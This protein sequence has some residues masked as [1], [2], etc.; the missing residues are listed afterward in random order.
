MTKS[1]KIT[2]LISIAA[3]L[4]FIM[5]SPWTRESVPFWTVMTVSGV[6]LTS[7]TL[8]SGMVKP[9]RPDC[10]FSGAV[11]GVISAIVLWGIFWIG[12]YLSVRW[13]DFAAGQI[14]SI[15]MIRE[16]MNKTVVSLLLLLIIGPA[17]E[18]FWR[19]CIQKY[20]GG[21]YD[22]VVT[23]LIYALVHIWSFN[24]MLVMAA[25]VCGLFWGLLYKLDGRLSVVIVSH[26][27]WD[28]AAFVLL[29][30]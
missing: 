8:L 29:P 6:I 4:W 20:I 13:F 3:L 11:L 10:L 9:V 19:G 1:L 14:D 23:A 21:K 28:V 2:G 30:I 18:I 27:L 24:F 16:G 17:E 25:L 12:K 5:F 26:A 22:F 15:Y 7:A